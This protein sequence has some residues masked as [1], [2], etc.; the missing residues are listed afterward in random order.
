V[1]VTVIGRDVG[2]GAGDLA[3]YIVIMTYLLTLGRRLWRE[4]VGGECLN[5][6]RD[7][8]A[9]AAARVRTSAGTRLIRGDTRSSPAPIIF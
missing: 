3:R 4:T 6:C 8:C 9:V 2:S 1:S 7:A 5:V